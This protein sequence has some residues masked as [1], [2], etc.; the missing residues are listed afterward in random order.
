MIVL[1]NDPEISLM[2]EAGRLV[3]Q[4]LDVIRQAVKPGVTTGKLDALAEDFIVSHNARPAFKNYQGFPATICASINEEVV[5]GIPGKRVLNEGDII[6]IDIGAFINGWC[7]DSAITVPVGE[8]SGEL[9]ELIKVTEESL[10]K[11]IEQAVAGNTL[12]RVSNAVQSHAEARGYAVVR[13]YVG[14]GIGQKMHE[15]PPVPNYG[16][17][18]RGPVLKPGMTLAI[19][20]M[21]NLG[22]SEVYT[23]M[24]NWTVVTRDGKASAHFEHTIAIT[25]HGPVILTLP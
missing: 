7:G 21:I 1:K 16:R 19:E 10:Y 20:P 18:E 17:P 15:D 8:V 13:Q 9:L 12:G 22:V 24:D 2:R 14:H 5:H 3:A 4:T 6:S 23:R 25:D 11:G